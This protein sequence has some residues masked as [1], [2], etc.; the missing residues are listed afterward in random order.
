MNDH[1]MM[2]YRCLVILAGMVLCLSPRAHAVDELVGFDL[3]VKTW[4]EECRDEVKSR[5]EMLIRTGKLTQ[6]QV[7][8]TFYVPVPNTYP[9]K[10]HTQYD[11]YS[12]QVLQDLLDN[13][14]KKNSRIIYFVAV[15]KNGYVPTH[16][17][18]YSQPITGNKAEDAK[19]NRTKTL[20]NDRTGLTA[21]KNTEPFLLQKYNRD[22]GETAYDLSVPLYIKGEHWGCIR[23]GYK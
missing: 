14:V 5:F 13:Y 22:T 3:Q 21:A 15:D 17:S 9:Q 7:F 16:N 8:D 23:V 11:K 4:A 2:R 12:D 10:Y 19:G 1:A 6:A 20:Y 18:R